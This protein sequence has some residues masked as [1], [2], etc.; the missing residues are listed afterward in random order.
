MMI[1]HNRHRVVLSAVLLA[2]CW[3]ATGNQP[4]EA[5]VNERPF[6]LPFA[7]KPGPSTWM[8]E[9][10][11]GNTLDA[12]NYGKYWYAAGQGLH[13]GMDLE[14]ACGTPV[15]AIADGVVDQIDNRLF[16]ADPH[17]LVIRHDQYNYVS[18]Y[19]HLRDKVKLTVGQPVSRGQVV[20]VVGD[21]DL[22]C[23]SRPHLHLEIRSLDY[24]V[25]YNPAPL[26]KA[27]W[28]MLYSLHP[29][30]FS[31]FAKDLYRPNRWQFNEDQP[32][33][34]FNGKAVNNYGLS[35]PA[36]YRTQPPPITLPANFAQPISTSMPVTLRK[37]TQAGCCTRPW[38]SA[39]SQA[40][41]YLNVVPDRDIAGEYQVAVTGGA[42]TL[43]GSTPPAIVAPNGKYE[44]RVIGN[45]MTLIE[46][47]TKKQTNLFTRG[48][49]PRF[50]PGSKQ[51]LWHI[52]PADDIPGEI[53]PRTEIWVADVMTGEA[54]LLRT[55]NGGAV[56]WLDEGR[57]LVS[58]IKNYSQD[59]S[60]S[61]LTIATKEV[62]PLIDASFMRSL[63]VS[64]G[65]KYLM[66]AL[67]F[68]DKVGDGGMYLLETTP[69]ATPK[70]LP[71][72]GGWRWRD[73]NSVLYIPFNEPTM[74]LV[75]YDVTTGREQP[76]QLSKFDS[77]SIATA[78]WEVSP[79]GRRVVF[80]AS[81]DH[82]IWV[83]DL[84]V[85]DWF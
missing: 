81:R 17:N 84:P 11:Y 6:S 83:M 42:A 51:L 59:I 4:I 68:Q 2:L 32:E 43:L 61:I 76:L 45:T 26:I 12:S 3:L 10:Y 27:N 22:N 7:T 35:W 79:D 34:G 31:G 57:L 44:V 18:V 39:D 41:R 67:F 37:L 48:A 71:F 62:Q 85:R 30:D 38:W 65:G 5:Q 70:K 9:Q 54:T 74:S 40:V 29:S 64:P 24:R 55:Q 14:A 82:A 1:V 66:Y 63:T 78:D 8:F 69:G 52:R 36:S 56:R 75:L 58:E 28:D 25:A 15:T 72:F 21:P 20:A 53:A 47:A 33:T 13:F 77:F 60:L 23:H 16:G 80:V 46:I 19:G 73:S 50:S 49:Y